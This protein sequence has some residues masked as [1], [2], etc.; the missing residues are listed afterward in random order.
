MLP[1][2]GV[3]TSEPLPPSQE[4]NGTHRA[5]PNHV[6]PVRLFQDF[7]ER[8]NVQCQRDC[9]TVWT[10]LE[11]VIPGC[12]VLTPWTDNTPPLNCRANEGIKVCMFGP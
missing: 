8:A 6:L 11:S 4:R 2:P 7:P 5:H 1:R 9:R 3:D 12:R 10:V